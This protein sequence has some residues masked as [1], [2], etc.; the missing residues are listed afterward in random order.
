MSPVC[1]FLNCSYA[2]YIRSETYLRQPTQSR[3]TIKNLNFK[4][5]TGPHTWLLYPCG[6]Q[7]KQGLCGSTIISIKQLSSTQ[8][9]VLST[10]LF[11][12]VLIPVYKW[13]WG[14]PSMYP[15]KEVR[16]CSGLGSGYFIWNTPLRGVESELW[17]RT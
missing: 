4:Y 15:E 17:L 2:L 13:L 9:A 8:C 7:M 11:L 10:T 3:H 14:S 1:F 6:L 16:L 12:T 5:K